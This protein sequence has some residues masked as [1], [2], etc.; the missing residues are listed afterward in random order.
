[1]L[2]AIIWLAFYKNY[3]V[4]SLFRHYN[5]LLLPSPSVE[6][7]ILLGLYTQNYL[8]AHHEP[9]YHDSLTTRMQEFGLTDLQRGHDIAVRGGQLGS[10]EYKDQASG[11]AAVFIAIWFIATS[12]TKPFSPL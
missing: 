3:Q 7:A 5:Q 12:S 10:F 4:Q 9:Q 1:M 11:V 6:Q 8:A 2:L